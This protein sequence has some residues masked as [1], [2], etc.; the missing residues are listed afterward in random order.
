MESVA[1]QTILDGFG[2]G[3]LIFASDGKLLQ[4]NMMAGTILGADL[5][6]IRRE[7]WSVA[8]EL[9]D[10]SSQPLDLRM[11]SIRDKALAS[12]RPIRFQI[13]RSGVYVPCWAA[14]LTTSDGDINLMLTLDMPDW[15]IITNVI[16][17]FSKE[18]QETVDSTLGHV[19][20]IERTLSKDEDDEAAKKVAKRI[21]GFT[22]LIA[23]H[24][25][26][27]ARLMKMLERLQDVRTGHIHEIIRNNRQQITLADFLED[28]V[29]ELEEIQFLD[30]ESETHDYRAR[31][32]IELDE[33]LHVLAVPRYLIYALREI[34]RNA[35]MYSMVGTPI[36]IQAQTVRNQIQIDIIDEG[37]GIREREYPRIFEPFARARQP[38]VIAEF[39]YGLALHLCKNEIEAMGGKLWFTSEYNVG[40]RFYIMLPHWQAPEPEL[41]VAQSDPAQNSDPS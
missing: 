37:Y 38:Q 8:A 35:I 39:G 41:E 18:M 12:E 24:M 4:S 23:I 26:R 17:R 34:L 32:H 36:T 31:F 30:P 2:H 19:N 40:T 14:A 28:F 22:R 9:F 25:A 20:L 29:E 10:T 11:A 13:F 15:E 3:V 21:G 6:I 27:S 33:D 5:N 1:L 16:G 7:G